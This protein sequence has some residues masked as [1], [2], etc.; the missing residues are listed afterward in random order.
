MADRRM[1]AALIHHLRRKAQFRWDRATMAAHQDDLDGPKDI[2][3][4]VANTHAR[5]NVMPG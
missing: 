2:G 4:I 5:M 3:R 1:R